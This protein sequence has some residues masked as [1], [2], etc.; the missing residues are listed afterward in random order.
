MRRYQSIGVAFSGSPKLPSVVA[1]YIKDIL[2]IWQCSSHGPGLASYLACQLDPNPD[3]DNRRILQFLEGYPTPGYPRIP[4]PDN[5]SKIMDTPDKDPDPDTLK[6]FGYPIR[7]MPSINQP[8][9]EE[10]SS[11]M[12][13]QAPLNLPRATHP[14]WLTSPPSTDK[15][16]P[17]SNMFTGKKRTKI[18]WS[19]SSINLDM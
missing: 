17:R 3:P 2:S 12:E 15:K 6:L 5:D 9:P 16:N 18:H 7:P 4:N 13:V 14:L 1:C 19:L 8:S 11:I 10:Y